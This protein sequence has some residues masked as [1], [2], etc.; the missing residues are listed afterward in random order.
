[1]LLPYFEWVNNLPVSRAIGESAL[2]YPV[3]QSIHLVFL[4]LLVGGIFM[5]D[6]RLMGTSLTSLPLAKVARDARPWVI[7]GLVGMLVTGIPQLM[8]NAT[9]EYHSEFFWFKMQLLPVALIYHFT[10]RHRITMAAEGR[11]APILSK[12]AGVVSIALW[13]SIAVTSRFI[14]LFT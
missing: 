9:R 7:W 2:I 1:M 13:T 5:V 11:V 4:A 12:L 3:V 6:L 8:Q 10:L 14:G